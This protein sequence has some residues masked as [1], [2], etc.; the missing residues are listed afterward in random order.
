V[1]ANREFKI[2]DLAAEL[3]ECVFVEWQDDAYDSR[4]LAIELEESASTGGK[5]GRPELFP[6]SR[7]GG[8]SPA[9][10]ISGIC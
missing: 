9:P 1:R 3:D 5:A 6:A 7:V 4:L 8:I 2:A 10:Q